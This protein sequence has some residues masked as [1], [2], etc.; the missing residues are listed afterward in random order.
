MCCKGLIGKSSFICFNFSLPIWQA[1][2]RSM[3]EYVCEPLMQL[4]VL[5][6]FMHSHQSQRF[7]PLI[8]M[9]VLAYASGLWHWRQAFC[10]HL[11]GLEDAIKDQGEC[12]KYHSITH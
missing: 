8:P 11:K 10:H 3:V 12:I 1:A 4:H 6:A 7:E 2:F 5:D 9:T